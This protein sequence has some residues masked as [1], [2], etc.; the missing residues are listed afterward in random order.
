M[1]G[2]M[3]EVSFDEETEAVDEA[4]EEGA[5]EQGEAAKEFVREKPNCF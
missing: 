2:D 1:D 3:Q 4:E 5:A